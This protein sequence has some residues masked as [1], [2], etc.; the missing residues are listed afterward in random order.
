MI[1]DPVLGQLAEEVGEGLLPDPPDALGGE[2]ETA[3]ALVDEP[4]V[5]ELLGQLG[6][7][8]Q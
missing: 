2:L 4:G 3:L 5:L 8:V 6:Q 1:P 7:S